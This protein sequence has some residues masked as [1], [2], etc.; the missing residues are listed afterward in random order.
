MRALLYARAGE[1][2]G[3]SLVEF[4]LLAPLL[5]LLVLG[6][7]DTGYLLLNQHVVTKLAREGSN[8]ISRNTSLEDAV[9]TLASM[10]ARPVDFG[11]RS[12]VIFSVLKR[13][14]TVGTPN[15]GRIILYQ[16]TEHG[17][18]ARTS[19]LATLGTG[20]FGGAPDYIAAS[21]DSDASLRVTNVPADLIVPK[22]GMIYITEVFTTHAALSPLARF[23][24][25]MP[26]TLYSIAYF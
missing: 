24:I 1:S 15:Y 2:H 9:D 25:D 18:L 13:G 6:V 10:S 26:S 7:V 12:R 8:L 11:T 17:V 14:A 22:G 3:Q 4:A 20:S 23:G 16:R 5:L 21:S 19:R